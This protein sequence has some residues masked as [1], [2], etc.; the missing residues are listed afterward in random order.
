MKTPL[1]T[2]PIEWRLKLAFGVI[3]LIL[4]GTSVTA[5]RNISRSLTGSDWVN[6]THAVILEGDAIR[7]SLNAGES[8]LR[9]HLL[10]SDPR[11]LADA[12]VA[13]AEAAEHL[14]LAKALTRNDPSGSQ[15]LARVEPLAARRVDF[16]REGVRLRQLGDETA[17]RRLLTAQGGDTTM[18]EIK[19]ELEEL[20]RYEQALLQERDRQSYLQAQ[21]TRWTVMAGVAINLGLLLFVAWLIRDDLRAR[22]LAAT[23]L[24]K[25]NDTLEAKVQERTRE[26]TAA[27]QALEL[28]NLERQWQ[29]QAIEHQLRYNQ[30]IIN[31]MDDLVLVTTKILKITRLTPA[32]TH[33]LGFTAEEMVGQPLQ[34]YLREGTGGTSIA[35]GLDRLIGALKE[36]RELQDCPGE[37]LAKDTRPIPVRFRLIPLRDHDQ[38]VGGVVSIHLSTSLPA[39]NASPASPTP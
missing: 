39:D 1:M 25:A 26:L 19:R 16:A 11:S 23:A 31:S 4:V 22:R 35:A 38:V 37:L 33:R 30:L 7:A 15:L 3:A 2:E 21:T 32:V 6:H 14:E 13:Y 12:R 20:K 34:R 27:N 18:A 8:A 17:I 36:G 29:Y 5:L 9:D 24:Q 28:E 10:T